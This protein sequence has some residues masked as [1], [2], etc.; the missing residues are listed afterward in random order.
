MKRPVTGALVLALIAGVAIF[1]QGG[2]ADSAPSGQPQAP[3]P[4]K[5]YQIAGPPPG[6]P[7]VELVTVFGVEPAVQVITPAFLCEP[8]L[9]DGV[10]NLAGTPYKAYLIAD[11]HDPDAVVDLETQFGLEEE[12]AVGPAQ[13]LWR[14]ALKVIEGGPPEGDLSQTPS[15]AT[16][17][18]IQLRFTHRSSW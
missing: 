11:T 6:V 18:P 15:N 8:A 9:K 1:W 12:V 2:A 4:Y 3:T 14:P 17:S 16:P 13:F 10:G 7:P 5:C